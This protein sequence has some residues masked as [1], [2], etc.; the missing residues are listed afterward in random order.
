MSTEERIT[1]TFPTW[2]F[3][4]ACPRMEW[5]PLSQ[6]T[7]T[8][9]PNV[10]TVQDL[11]SA[12]ADLVVL[13]V[14]VDA[15]NDNAET[16][17][18]KKPKELALE[19]LAA[20]VDETVTAGTLAQ[21]LQEQSKAL[22]KA[23]GTSPTTRVVSNGKATRYALLAVGSVIKDSGSI[24][25]DTSAAVGFSLGKSIVKLV[26]AE[27]KISTAMIVLPTT[28]TSNK[29]V[30]TDLVTAI[31]QSL[32]VDDRF[33]S[34]KKPTAEDLTSI[35]LAW[36]DAVCDSSVITIG[37]QIAAGV[38]MTKDIVNAPHNV[39]NSTSLAETAQRIASASTG[40]CV[41]C[42]I[43]DAAACEAR[44]MGAYLGVARGSETPPQFIHLTYKPT[45]GDIKRKVALVGKGVLFDTGGYNIK[46][47]MMDL[48]KFDCGGAAAV[49][50]AARAISLLC[51]P[52]V[53]AHFIVAVRLSTKDT[54][55]LALL[56]FSHTTPLAY[57]VCIIAFLSLIR[58]ART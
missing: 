54:I 19:G 15:S 58:L 41:T 39:L 24:D 14:L 33:R 51:P 4:K 10:E 27:K 7:L 3:D 26:A 57:N 21:V 49:L 34:K 48:M 28:L 36:Q 35:I 23:S 22:G 2:T 31:Y 53:E 11:A 38:L 40:G 25:K 44:G 56:C 47:Q 6:V 45:N 52:G 55:P 8:L 9:Q 30:M 13:P 16:T 50:G 18:D 1:P 32:Y 17:D 43:L 5:T 12:A 20:T 29:K 37:Q 46:M 42:T